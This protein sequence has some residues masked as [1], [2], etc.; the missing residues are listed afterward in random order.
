[1]KEES[2]MKPLEFEKVSVEEARWT[3]EGK[4]V[5]PDADKSSD[6][7]TRTP[8]EPLLDVTQTWLAS[9]PQDVRPLEL[10]RQFPRIANRLGR[11][12]KQV[13][14]CEEHLDDLLV[15][16]R[17]TRKGFPPIITQELEA[18]REYYALLHPDG[19]SAWGH[20][21]EGR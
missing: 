6:R 12:W 2:F 14:R 17:G 16:R 18:L 13:A 21:E 10:P 15:N 4:P 7:R 11:L 20:V 5:K 1:L 9:L 8:E 19:R 3:L